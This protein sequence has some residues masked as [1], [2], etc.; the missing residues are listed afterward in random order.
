MK[1]KK[2]K[3]SLRRTLEVT[4]KSVF[5]LLYLQNTTL[6]RSNKQKLQLK[7]LKKYANFDNGYFNL[8]LT[9]NLRLQSDFV[10]RRPRANEILFPFELHKTIFSSKIFDK[11]EEAVSRLE[12]ETE[13]DTASLVE[14]DNVLLEMKRMKGA[15]MSKSLSFIL[16]I[17]NFHRL[18]AITS[19]VGFDDQIDV[20]AQIIM[21]E[22]FP[23][24][25]GKDGTNIISSFTVT[26]QDMS[27]LL[28]SSNFATFIDTL[29]ENTEQSDNGSVQ[30]PPAEKTVLVFG[31]EEEGVGESQILE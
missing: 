25:E 5:S 17:S 1:V 4:P 13:N 14:I 29:D 27:A 26:A 15:D 7:T 20:T 31:D 16:R 8:A 24:V 11:F 3:I 9:N 28:T 22:Q 21:L 10:Q 6:L 12:K 18:H 19:G 23:D 30:Q 2:Q